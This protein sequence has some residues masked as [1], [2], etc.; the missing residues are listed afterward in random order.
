MK[1]LT[2]EQLIEAAEICGSGKEGACQVCPAHN[3]G[4]VMSSACIE[5]VMAQAAAA[6]KEYACNG[7]AYDIWSKRAIRY[8]SSL[9]CR[10]IETSLK[11]SIV[12][13]RRHAAITDSAQAGGDDYD[14]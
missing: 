12:S 2:L 11:S 3:D 4:E 9:F 5:S 10:F 13:T 8:R 1:T 14:V 6:L 7:G